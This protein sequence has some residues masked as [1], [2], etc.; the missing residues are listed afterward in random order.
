MPDESTLVR[1]FTMLTKRED[2]STEEF[3]D[4]WR[5]V[6]APMARRL[7]GLVAYVQ[8]HV[9]DSFARSDV[10]A[11]DANIDGVTELVFTS[12]AAMD[13]ALNSELGRRLAE[14]AKNFMSQMR[15]YVVE[16]VVIV[17]P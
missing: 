2:L 3:R 14:D 13:E 10:P 5:N 15:G 8:H 12:R 16:D 11:P 4:Y 6:H 1:N 7:P 17:E 9:V